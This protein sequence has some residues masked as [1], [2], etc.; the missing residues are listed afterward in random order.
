MDWIRL[1]NIESQTLS[2]NLEKI[3]SIPYVHFQLLSIIDTVNT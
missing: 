2:E 1:G 3:L